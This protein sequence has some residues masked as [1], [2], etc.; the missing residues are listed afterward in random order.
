MHLTLKTSMI[1]AKNMDRMVAFYRDGLGLPLIENRADGWASFDA[2]SATL[3]LHAIPAGIAAG[4]EITEPPQAREDSAIKLIFATD[5][6]AAA[7]A[8]L[9]AHGATMSAP[10]GDKSCDGLDPEGNVFQIVRR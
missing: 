2:G 6:V 5:D 7:R 9:Q 1:F 4:I 3:A 8:H 10:R